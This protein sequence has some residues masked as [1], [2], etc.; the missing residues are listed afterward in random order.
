MNT[1]TTAFFMPEDID[2][3]AIARAQKKAEQPATPPLAP[4]VE[5]Y[6]AATK[7]YHQAVMFNQ[8]SFR[9][10]LGSGK[11]QWLPGTGD[12]VAD[13]ARRENELYDGAQAIA[14]FSDSLKAKG[15]G[16]YAD[17]ANLYT[18]SIDLAILALALA[19]SKP[20]DH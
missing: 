17:F 4:T 2:V 8:E 15:G 5:N 9:R 6:V 7:A 20:N 10:R 19:D 3:L 14:E 11:S 18:V 13:L 16:T 12:A 1:D